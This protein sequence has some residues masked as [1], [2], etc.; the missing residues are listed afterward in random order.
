[1]ERVRPLLVAAC[2]LLV[3]VPAA[4]AQESILFA[5]PC[6]F[7]HRA[8]DDPI[9]LPGRPGDSHSHDFFGNVSTD[10][11]S[12][13]STLTSAGAT[14]CRRPL[15]RAGY[16]VPT[17][18]LDGRP[19][20][21]EL[22]QIY[23]QAAA[24]TRANVQPLPA[25]LR[26]VAGDAHASAPQRM[27]VTSWH[28]AERSDIP[29]S[30]EVPVCP[31]G[32]DLILHLRFPEC[33]DG[34]NLDSPDHQGH[35]AYGTG[36]GCPSSH[37]VLVPRVLFSVHYAIAGGPGVTLASGP[38]YSAHG[39]FFNAWDQ[40]ELERLVRQCINALARQASACDPRGPLPPTL[41]LNAE[42]LLYRAPLTLEGDAGAA[43]TALRI[44]AESAGPWRPLTE[45]AAGPAGRFRF[46]MPAEASSRFRAITAEGRASRTVLVHVR[47]QIAVRLRRHVRS[48]RRLGLTT[49]VSPAKR[50]VILRAERLAGGNWRLASRQALRTRGGLARG[51]LRLR[52]PGRYRVR[53][54]TL[55]D[56]LHAAG[57]SE[58]R[59]VEVV[60]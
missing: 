28:C 3:L 5:S 21:P 19:V 18:Y 44:E 36:A 39:D 48:G 32:H 10:A 51:A 50:R 6:G 15:D 31:S 14:T 41:E 17:L 54:L 53:A 42:S 45:L 27:G 52:R 25:G 1:M 60:R 35:M 4:R 47:P 40:T 55:A 34:H 59:F 38:A 26:I 12:T 20:T 11:A 23:Y 46:T 24:R 30:S 2:L 58:Y 29:A 7:S 37:P 57:R 56:D 22:A 33:W 16:W 49:L 9:V 13:H 8:S 43:G